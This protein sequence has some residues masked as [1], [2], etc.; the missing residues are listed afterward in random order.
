MEAGED[1]VGYDAHARRDPDV[2]E[3]AIREYLDSRYAAFRRR[4]GRT[5][6]SAGA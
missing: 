6:G 1:Q 4:Y 2:A 3:T 5:D